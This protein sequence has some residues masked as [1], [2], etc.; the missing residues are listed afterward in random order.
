MRRESRRLVL[1]LATPRKRTAVVEQHYKPLYHLA[2][3]TVGRFPGNSRLAPSIPP[4]PLRLKQSG[5]VV[6]LRVPELDATVHVARILEATIDDSA[7]SGTI[8][9]F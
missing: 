9:A 7:P 1:L 4:E 2:L 3:R 6:S 8:L 5:D